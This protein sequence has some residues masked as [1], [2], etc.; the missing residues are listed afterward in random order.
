MRIH[1]KLFVLL[2]NL[3]G[4]LAAD[5]SR[6]NIV[7]IMADDLGYGDV[8]CYGATKIKTPNIDR[9]AGEGMMF[10]DAHTAASVCSPSRYGLMTGRPAETS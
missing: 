1:L 10:T 4:T 8:G 9:L 6:P 7:I 3:S 5:D 2:A